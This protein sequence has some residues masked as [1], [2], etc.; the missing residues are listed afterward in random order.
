M[1]FLNLG[2]KGLTHALFFFYLQADSPLQLRKAVFDQLKK[3]K[4]QA[5]GFVG[6]QGEWIN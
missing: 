4:S 6:A 1:Y 5:S 2:V 3:F